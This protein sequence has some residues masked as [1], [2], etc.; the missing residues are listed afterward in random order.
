MKKRSKFETDKVDKKHQ[1]KKKLNNKR[2]PLTPFQLSSVPL[3]SEH[4]DSLAREF[5]RKKWS[6]RVNDDDENEN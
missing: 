6:A 2:V 3:A 5:R 1:L 4:F